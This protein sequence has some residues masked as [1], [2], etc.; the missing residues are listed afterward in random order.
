MGLARERLDL[1]KETEG[2]HELVVLNEL[3]NY[4]ARDS[5]IVERESLLLPL[6]TYT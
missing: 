6:S 1:I 5:L 2:I 3:C 4:I